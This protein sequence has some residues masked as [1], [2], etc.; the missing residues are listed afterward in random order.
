[1]DQ[2]SD[3]IIMNFS[4]CNEFLTVVGIPFQLM[5]DKSS[6]TVTVPPT[7]Q[8]FERLKTIEKEHRDALERAVSL[9]VPHAVDTAEKEPSEHNEG[10]ASSCGSQNVSST[11]SKSSGGRLSWD[12]V[13][14]KLLK[15]NKTGDL[16]GEKKDTN[17]AQ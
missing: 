12:E 2:T 14:E 1:M 3:E 7:V 16:N 8:K 13:V 4:A 15:K 11:E 10:E 9:N 6:E 5:K 17:V